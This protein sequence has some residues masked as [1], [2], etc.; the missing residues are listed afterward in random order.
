[1][2][3]SMKNKAQKHLQFVRKHYIV[4]SMDSDGKTMFGIPPVPMHS[5]GHLHQGNN[6]Q[7]G[8]PIPDPHQMAI[9][10]SMEAVYGNP[11][12]GH[13]DDD[14]EDDDDDDD[15]YKDIPL[16]NPYGRRQL[17]P[18]PDTDSIGTVSPDWRRYHQRY[19]HDY[20]INKL[21]PLKF[22]SHLSHSSNN[23]MS[24]HDMATISTVTKT[25]S[26]EESHNDEEKAY[27]PS[28]PGN[29]PFL[30]E[31][32]KNSHSHIVEVRV[33]IIIISSIM[34]VHQEVFM[35]HLCIHHKHPIIIIMIL[36][37]N[38]FLHNIWKIPS[39]V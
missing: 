10:Q 7:D 2:E 20:T 30:L 5:P 23:S 9:N 19:N 31:P 27:A 11:S 25:P 17:R 35:Y 37:R 32:K 38:I 29:N 8:I 18:L 28:Q 39:R 21:N 36:K 3:K 13:Q 1:M 4:G 12:S 33:V 16:Q 6:H 26:P 15:E 34:I 14:D 22:K 24:M